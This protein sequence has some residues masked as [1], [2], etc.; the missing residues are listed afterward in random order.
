MKLVTSLITLFCG[1]GCAL[2]QAPVTPPPAQPGYGGIPYTNQYV[3]SA[4]RGYGANSYNQPGTTFSFNG[5]T[6]SV[7][8]LA[9]QLQNLQS[10]VEQALPA[11]A[12]FNANFVTRTANGNPSIG[13]TISNLLSDVLHR[14]ASQGSPAIT[15]L[16]A[17]LQSPQSGAPSAPVTVTSATTQD[18]VT[19]Q[20][21]LNPLPQLF[22]GLGMR[23][24]LATGPSQ[25]ISS[26]G[27]PGVPRY[28]GY[29]NAQTNGY[30]NRYAPTGR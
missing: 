15:N 17:A 13:G 12:A 1:I 22:Q 7:N 28:P 26:P 5:Q 27:Y 2:A 29:G 9:S 19:L 14:N 10:A 11:L 18:L 25:V 20:N 24:G 3:P 8:Q 6:Y 30:P 23:P 16:V 4:R 21:D